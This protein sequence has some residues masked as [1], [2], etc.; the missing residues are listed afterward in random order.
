MSKQSTIPREGVE[1]LKLVVARL[2][3]NHLQRR[4]SALYVRNEALPQ[5]RAWVI[6]R[7]IERL[8]CRKEKT[9][10]Y[11][12]ASLMDIGLAARPALTV[13]F[14]HARKPSRQIRLVN[15]LA[16]V[17]CALPPQDR[18][19]IQISLMMAQARTRNLDVFTAIHLAAQI[20]TQ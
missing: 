3:S 8:H 12:T 20:L 15:A 2:S 9:R 11:A 6:D 17:G 18:T 19:D 7:L 13:A 4:N 10:K 16:A 14:L 1:K 5:I